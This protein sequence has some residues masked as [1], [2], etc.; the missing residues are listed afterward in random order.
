MRPV[1]FFSD[2]YLEQCRQMK[3]ADIL[4]FLDE[5][6]RLHAAPRRKSRLISLKVPEELLEA[7]KAKARLHDVPYQ[8]QIKRLMTEWLVGRSTDAD[9]AGEP[10]APG[11][12]S[13]TKSR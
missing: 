11:R 13:R 8:T 9:D 12:R 2:E 1:Q 4:R 7:F 10:E 6:R 3:P 5:F